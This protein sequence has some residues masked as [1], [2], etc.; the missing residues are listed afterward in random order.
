MKK[1][2]EITEFSKNQIINK[3]NSTALREDIIAK[4]KE[5]LLQYSKELN[6]RIKDLVKE[7]ACIIKE[8]TK[9]KQD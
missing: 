3:I 9:G 8:T 5:E 6:Y 4:T 1:L 2:L 7:K